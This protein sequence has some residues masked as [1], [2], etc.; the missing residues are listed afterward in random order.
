[1]NKRTQQIAAF[2]FGVVFVSILLTL[3]IF[4]STPTSFQYLV[5]KTVLSLAAAGIAA[6][7]PGFL[8]VTLATWLRAGGALAVFVVVYFYNPAQ[9]FVS[10]QK[11]DSKVQLVDYSV[12]YPESEVLM[13]EIDVKLRNTGDQVAFI[14]KIE[15]DVLG[16]A[17][18]ENCNRPSYRLVEAS[19]EY[20][21]DI[22]G[23][24][25]K[26]ISHSIK[27]ADVDRFKVRVFRANGGPTL[28]VYKVALN[29][30]YDEDNKVATSSEPIFLK[31]VGPAVPVG[32]FIPGVSEQEWNACVDRNRE[33]FGKIGYKVYKDDE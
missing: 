23:S 15:F 10:Q 13:P 3:A 9:L 29:V 5:F 25:G 7:V 31:M 32:S 18:F 21:V 4:F 22:L 17:T 12:A 6:M 2:S 33:A 30:V 16:E 28:T 24:R 20:D 11:T 27:P 1:M 8:Q 19:A 26:E 14:K